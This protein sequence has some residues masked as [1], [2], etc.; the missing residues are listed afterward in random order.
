M[1]FESFHT[2]TEEVSNF[3]SFFFKYK[4]FYKIQIQSDGNQNLGLLNF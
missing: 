3:R 2:K 4:K 1:T